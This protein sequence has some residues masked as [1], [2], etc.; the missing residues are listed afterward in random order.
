MYHVQENSIEEPKWL[1]L[2]RSCIFFLTNYKVNVRTLK[3]T[4]MLSKKQ[5]LILNL[6][7]SEPLIMGELEQEK[8]CMTKKMF[9]IYTDTQ[10]TLAMK[11]PKNSVILF[12]PWEN[13]KISMNKSMYNVSSCDFETKFEANGRV[14]VLSILNFVCLWRVSLGNQ[15]GLQ[16]SPGKHACCNA[17]SPFGQMLSFFAWHNVCSAL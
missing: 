14:L 5:S 3:T 9:I 12:K 1:P 10:C 11:K 6:N 16:S 13:S 7:C 2:T 17:G 8:Y 15:C 4:N